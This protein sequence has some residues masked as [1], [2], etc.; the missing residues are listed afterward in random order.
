MVQQQTLYTETMDKTQ[1][2]QLIEA[3]LKD[4]ALNAKIPSIN[5]PHAVNLIQG[6]IAQESANGFYIRQLGNGPALGIAQMESATFFD[7]VQNYLDYRPEL[8]RAVI[9]VANVR[10]LTPTALMYN[11]RLSIIFARLLFMRVPA[12]L[13]TTI[14]GYAAYWKDH[15]NTHLGKGTTAEFIANYKKYVS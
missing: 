12:P 4:L 9:N 3:T 6:T 14:E 8:K 7:I 5:T 15:Y 2:K 11:A 1:L 10:D 13:P